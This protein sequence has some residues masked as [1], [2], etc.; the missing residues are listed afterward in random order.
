MIVLPK[1]RH[2]N[3]GMVRGNRDIWFVRWTVDGKPC[4]KSTGTRDANEA[5]GIRDAVYAS[6]RRKHG[7]VLTIGTAEH[8]LAT[9]KYIY[10]RP[11]YEV[12][13]P[14]AK[15]QLAKTREEAREIRDELLK[16]R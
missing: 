6:L 5:R 16:G 15:V 9:D 2:A 11:P 13:V 4:T 7:N 12:R 10:E 1:P 8:A 14:G 3:Y